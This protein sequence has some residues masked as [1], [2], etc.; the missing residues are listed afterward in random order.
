MIY[1]QTGWERARRTHFDEIAENYD[2]ARWNYPDG[3][4]DDI[5]NY[6]GS[7]ADKNAVEVG[8]GT[9]KATLPF[10]N[11]GYTVTAVELGA[12]MSDFLRD[13]FKRFTGS[14][15]FSVINAAFEDAA[16]EEGR[17]D[18]IYA[19]S[20]FHWVDA[21]TGCPKAFRLLKPGGVFA[22]FRCNGAPD[23]ND[24]CYAEIQLAYEKYYYTQYPS[25]YRPARKT[26]EE[27]KTSS[28]LQRGYGFGDMRK[29][30]FADIIIN[31]YDASLTYSADAY[32]ALLDTYSDHRLLKEK[33]ALYG[34]VKEAIARHGGRYRADYTFQLYIGRRPA[35]C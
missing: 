17:Y 27:F 4:Y 28:E 23:I 12:N 1:M 32:A 18:L 22:L 5:F 16:L 8:A 24:P 9:G 15:R 7:D 25:T 34:A 10:L 35:E 31:H 30:G 29:Y 3:L 6:I 20:A 14:G 11:A 21:E 33:E 26:H 19:A 2:K 13:R